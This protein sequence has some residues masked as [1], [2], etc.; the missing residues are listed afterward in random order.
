MLDELPLFIEEWKDTTMER[1]MYPTWMLER[2]LNNWEMQFYPWWIDF[3]IWTY[4]FEEGRLYKGNIA[5]R[6][7]LKIYLLIKNNKYIDLRSFFTKEPIIH[8]L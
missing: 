8:I 7:F 1:C 3:P 5:Y 4:P 6:F 2:G